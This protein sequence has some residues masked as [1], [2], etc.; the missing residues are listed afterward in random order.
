MGDLKEQRTLFNNELVGILLASNY[1]Y[2]PT[3]L[4]MAW[5]VQS[6]GL[7]GKKYGFG[8]PAEKLSQID[9]SLSQQCKPL[10]TEKETMRLNLLV[11][12]KAN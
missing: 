8:G 10:S 11:Y 4:Q 7:G 5:D 2:G 6:V 1:S 12:R 9:P 3:E